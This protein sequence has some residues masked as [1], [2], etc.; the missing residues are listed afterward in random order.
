MDIDGAWFRSHP[1]RNY[2]VRRAIQGELPGLPSDE[3][4]V[5]VRQVIPGFRLRLSFL[6]TVA[7]PKGDAPED[8][9]HAIFDVM[10]EAC[11]QSTKFNEL[12]RALSN[13]GIT[14][15]D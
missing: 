2:R 12:S 6:P 7:L 10:A 11:G 13:R 8:I 5:V 4:Y 14:P 15:G 9:A 1:H 3:W